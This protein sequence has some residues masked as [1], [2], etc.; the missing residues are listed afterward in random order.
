MHAITLHYYVK[1]ANRLIHAPISMLCIVILFC[2][3]VNNLMFVALWILAEGPI[4]LW[5]CS[6]LHYVNVFTVLGF[7]PIVESTAYD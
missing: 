1:C 3:V 5:D 4:L 7:N 6:L 2:L